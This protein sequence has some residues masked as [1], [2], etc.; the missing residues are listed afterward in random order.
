MADDHGKLA[1]TIIDIQTALGLI[2]DRLDIFADK[3]RDHEHP[4]KPL[5]K[6]EH[7]EL[8]E[9]RAAVGVLEQRIVALT[10]ELAGIRQHVIAMAQS[11]EERA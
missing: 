5:P 9:L 8:F 7:S 6:H 2:N 4:A 3:L 11:L 1:S 10:D